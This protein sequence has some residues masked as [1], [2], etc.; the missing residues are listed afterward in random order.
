[1]IIYATKQT[2]EEYQIKM[3]WELPGAIG[4]TVKSTIESEQDNRLFQW[5]A[6]VFYFDKR[7]SIQLVNFASKLTLF[8]ID[9]GTNDIWNTG[10][11][12]VYYLLDLYK[13]DSQ[14]QTYLKKM[15]IEAPICCF[16]KLTDKSAIATLNRTQL[17]FAEDGDR[18]YDFIENG[19]LK[20]KEINR[21]VNTKWLFTQTVNKKTEYFYAAEKFKQLLEER[22][23]LRLV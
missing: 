3:P 18:F 7:K 19:I 2:V 20:T 22:Y 16:S 13:D 21:L 11:A 5:G 8:L 6:K 10:D 15:F 14:M 1:M 23:H 17:S 9:F 4:E 12:I